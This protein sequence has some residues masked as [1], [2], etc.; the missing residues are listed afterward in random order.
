MYEKDENVNRE[1]D[2]NKDMIKIDINDINLS[3]F[4]Q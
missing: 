1:Q 4:I 2:K 3:K